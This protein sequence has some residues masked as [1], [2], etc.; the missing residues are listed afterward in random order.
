[1]SMTPKEKLDGFLAGK[2]LINTVSG[3]VAWCDPEHDSLAP[4]VAEDHGVPYRFVYWFAPQWKVKEEPKMRYMNKDEFIDWQANAVGKVVLEKGMP[5]IMPAQGV[6]IGINFI[7][8]FQWSESSPTGDYV[9][10]DFTVEDKNE[11]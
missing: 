10:H 6:Y 9:W 4:F 11:S 2:T 8:N 5:L 3:S 7:K 1:M